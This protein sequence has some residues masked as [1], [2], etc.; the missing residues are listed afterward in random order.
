L[1]NNKNKNNRILQVALNQAKFRLEPKSMKI[2]LFLWQLGMALLNM[3][4]RNFIT[5]RG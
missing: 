5:N 2:R 1:K 4:T 3:P